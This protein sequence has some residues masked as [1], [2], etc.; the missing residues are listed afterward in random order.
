MDGRN[1]FEEIFVDFFS[2]LGLMTIYGIV[3]S[4][5]GYRFVCMFVLGC[6]SAWCI[7]QCK[8]ERSACVFRFLLFSVST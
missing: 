1:G 7:M 8:I 5:S 2:P 3:R 4:C 6:R